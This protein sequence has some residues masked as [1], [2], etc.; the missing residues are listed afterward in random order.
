MCEFRDIMSDTISAF[1]DSTGKTC[2]WIAQ[3]AEVG[4]ETVRR[5]LQKEAT[6][7]VYNSRS[8]LAAIDCPI[9]T[10]SEIM[11]LHPRNNSFN[12][13]YKSMTANDITADHLSRSTDAMLING[14]ADKNNGTNREE[15]L[16]H[17]P[18]I[19]GEVLIED[20][21]NKGVLREI[22]GRIKAKRYVVRHPR[23]QQQIND[24]INQL[25]KQLYKYDEHYK[26]SYGSFVGSRNQAGVDRIKDLTK[27]YFE[28]LLDVIEDP[29]FDGDEVFYL[30]VTQIEVK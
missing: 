21:L 1:I 6:P 7:N 28:G 19:S 2:A 18:K 29:E 8:I 25:A 17:L 12:A 14:L 13:K 9:N 15:L 3:K 22:N 5:A 30:G 10:V 24:S 23:I 16:N 11:D 27:K 26:T 20:L 4:Q